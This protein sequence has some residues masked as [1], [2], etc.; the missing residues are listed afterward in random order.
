MHWLSNSQ[1]G[2]TQADVRRSADRTVKKTLTHDV[3]N[4][5]MMPSVV[6]P[7]TVY[8]TLISKV[9]ESMKGENACT[10]MPVSLYELV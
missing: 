6:G 8:I 2:H 3:G 10:Y 7:T 4:A 9:V 5:D 1:L